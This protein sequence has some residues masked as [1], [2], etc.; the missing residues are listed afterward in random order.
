[1]TQIAYF[2]LTEERS[3]SGKL[4]NPV[5]SF[6]IGNGARLHSKNVHFAANRTERGLKDSCGIMV[7]YVYS[8]TWLHQ[9]RRSA[10]AMLPWK[11]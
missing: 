9:L 4:I 7:S 10:R 2:Y 3:T 5:A 1:M 6:H 11:V 8:S